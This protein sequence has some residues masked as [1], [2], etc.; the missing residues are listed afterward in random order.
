[1][2]T[3]VSIVKCKTYNPREVEGSVDKAFGLLGGMG[4]FVKKGEKVLLK[5]NIL[6]RRPPEDGVNTHV[7]VTR[8][9]VRLV[10]YC[11]AVPV[12]GDNPGG[13]VTPKD[14][15]ECSGFSSLAREEGIEIL[16]GGNVKMLRGVPISSYFFEC[17]KII[18]IPKMKTHNLMNLTGAI[19]NMFGAVSGLHKSQCHKRCPDP[20][21]FADILVDVF[22]LVKPHLVLMDGVI[23]MDGNG[24]AAGDL[25]PVGLLI[26]G[27]DS[28][29]V[30]SV[31]S[32]LIGISPFDLVT[33]KEAYRRGL[34]EIKL[35]N[36][37][38]LGE[39]I[40]ENLIKGFKLPRSKLLLKLPKGVVSMLAGLVR[41]GP[42]INT[43][44]CKKCKICAESCPVSAIT[45][46]S[47]DS[48]IDS[49]KC[50]KCMCCHEVCPYKAV[51]LRRNIL[52]RV[53][54]L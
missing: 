17:D 47:R 6:S 12:I 45:I 16:E 40:K 50:I 48:V 29:A 28:V 36:I 18:S 25:K 1:M 44:L 31:F 14:A 37:D 41:F 30:D 33:I 51:E 22:E 7:E 42:Y 2:K 52:A 4:S 9:V 5:P 19:K 21:E 26:A 13:S 39:K 11:G 35:E 15:Y 8:A 46:D 23:A 24:P 20:E 49:G 10:K 32:H 3:K 34:G 38:I 43:E 54:G 27:Q 53:L